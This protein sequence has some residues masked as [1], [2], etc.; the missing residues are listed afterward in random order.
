MQNFA[1]EYNRL[2]SKTNKFW[3]NKKFTEFSIEY[4]FLLLLIRASC[5]PCQFDFNSIH[6]W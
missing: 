3:K 1:K 6:P 4:S 2:I 5:N